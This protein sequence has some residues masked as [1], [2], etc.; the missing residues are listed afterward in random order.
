[1]LKPEGED[2]PET[3]YWMTRLRDGA[4]ELV[5]EPAPTTKTTPTR[6]TRRTAT[7]DEGQEN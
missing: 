5:P 2:V 7:L 1:V 4:I 3:Q 6:R